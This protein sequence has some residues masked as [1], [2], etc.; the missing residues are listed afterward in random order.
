MPPE[1]TEVRRWLEKVDHDRR[2]AESAL[3][4]SVP[5]TD[6]AAYH[7]QQAVEK[8]FKAFLVWHESP[9]EK[10]HDLEVLA[11]SCS[12]FDPAFDALVETV[13][14]LTMYGVRFRYPGP[15]DPNVD[16]VRDALAIVREVWD[17]VLVR[18]PIGIW[19]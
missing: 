10:V 13:A 17:F 12:R 5:V 16:E 15:N 1:L 4:L 6:T 3:A 2:T 7:C 18:L 9:F 11:R 14:P 19:P 8:L